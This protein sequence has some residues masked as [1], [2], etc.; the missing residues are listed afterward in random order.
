MTPPGGKSDDSGMHVMALHTAGGVTGS[1]RSRSRA[2][3]EQVDVAQLH[4][5][6]ECTALPAV[7]P[8][9]AGRQLK[10]ELQLREKMYKPRKGANE[11]KYRQLR[12]QLF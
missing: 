8:N 9:N 6:R 2:G 3:D 4:F 5:A 10:F 11:M 7:M 12:V 1:E